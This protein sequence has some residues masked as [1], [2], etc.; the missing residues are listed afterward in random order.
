[1]KQ[2]FVPKYQQLFDYYKQGIHAFDFKPG[3]KL[4]SIT[5]IQ[6]RFSVSRETAKQVLNMLAAEGLIIQKAG[7]G[8]FVVDLA[9]KKKEWGVI[10][11]FF[12]PNAELLLHYLRQEAQNKDR[13]ISYYLSYNNPKEEI[14]LVGQLLHDGYEAIVVVPVYDESETADFYRK[15]KPGPTP[16]ILAD[17]TMAGSYFQYVIQSYDLGLKR[18]LDYLMDK[19]ESNLLFIGDDA[20]PGKN[21]VAE[22]LEETFRLEVKNSPEQREGFVLES[23]RKLSH[24]YLIANNIGGL[25]CPNDTIAIRVLGRLKQWQ[26]AVPQEMALVSYGNSELAKFFTPAITS[27]NGHHDQIARSLSQIILN[28]TNQQERQEVILPELIIRET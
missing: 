11:P 15:L 7:K 28:A 5:A 17:H 18:A 26:I 22:L 8:S 14:N 21:M 1:M 16:I 4:D 10:I 25:F 3:A 23:F 24:E 13:E 6:A 20:L 27:V 9:R 2:A 12:T 19:C